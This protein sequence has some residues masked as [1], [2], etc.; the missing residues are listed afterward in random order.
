MNNCYIAMNTYPPVGLSAMYEFTKIE[1]T[2]G[3]TV[4]AIVLGEQN[5][6]IV[7]EQI[8]QLKVV[9]LPN[10]KNENELY[11]K[12]KF[13]IN[14]LNYLK[15]KSFDVV[16][17]YTNKG[18]FIYPLLL[19]HKKNVKWIYHI[20]TAPIYPGLRRIIGILLLRF[21]SLFFNQVTCASF[22]TRRTVFGK[23]RIDIP[24]IAVAVNMD[25][26]KKINSAILNELGIINA[27][28]VLV[29][30]GSLEPVRRLDVL[31]KAMKK[32][33]IDY[34]ADTRLLM[35]GPGSDIDRLKLLAKEL[36][37]SESINFTGPIPFDRIP[38]VLSMATIGLGYVPNTAGFGPQPA[39]KTVEMLASELPVIATDTEGNRVFI[40]D[41]INGIL[42]NDSDTDI[43]KAIVDLIENPNEMEKYRKIARKS[44][45]KFDYKTVFADSVIPIYQ[46]LMRNN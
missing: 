38:E 11:R 7:E 25:R 1:M 8:D 32:V 36:G 39:L 26:F 29:Y 27:K 43:A 40:Q 34:Q 10:D 2:F 46:K 12:I 18:S 31:I 6:G 42:V 19:S 44:I 21:D 23:N 41:G 4:T 30:I 37:I 24:I 20:R 17:V 45:Q 15:N 3:N 13:F 22:G 35:I 9:R 16:N 5:S 33:L 14:V 28:N